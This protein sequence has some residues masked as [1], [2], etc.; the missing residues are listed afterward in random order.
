MGSEKGVTVGFEARANG[1]KV[2]WVADHLIRILG[3]RFG[4]GARGLGLRCG[5]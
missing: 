5:V 2:Q 3:L 4:F 1:S